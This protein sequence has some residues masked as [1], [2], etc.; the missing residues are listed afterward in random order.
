MKLLTDVYYLA[1]LLG[2]RSILAGAAASLLLVPFSIRLSRN[3]RTKR[4]KRMN[5]HSALSKLV[6]ES[7][8][9]LRHIR[10]SSMEDIWKGRLS[11]IRDRELDQM[12]ST[13]I[14]M[15]LLSLAINLSPVLLVSTALFVYVYQTGHLNSSL[16]F[17]ALNLFDS[18]HIAFQEL[19]SRFAEARISWSSCKLIQRFLNEPDRKRSAISSDGLRLENADLSWHAEGSNPNTKSD[20]TLSNVN[21][22]FPPD[23]L[24][25]VVGGTGSGKSL[26]LAAMLEEASIRS[27]RL[28][29]PLKRTT[30]SKSKFQIIAGSTAL[31]SQ[32][33]WI[34]NRTIYENIIFGSIYDEARYKEVLDACVLNQDLSALPKGDQTIAGLNGAVLSGGQKWR[35][36]LA[37]AFYS[38]AEILFLDDVLSAVDTRVA[39]KISEQLIMGDLA[40]ERTII[41]VT[42][43]SETSLTTAK[44]RVIVENGKVNGKFLSH[45]ISKSRSGPFLVLKPLPES[46]SDVENESGQYETPQRTRAGLV[47]MNTKQILSAYVWASGGILSLAIGVLLTF[48]SRV[49]THSSSWWLSRW[50]TQDQTS[51]DYSVAYS[52]KIYFA[53]S[54]C[55]VAG[56]EVKS[57]VLLN[58]SLGASRSLFQRLVQSVL[59][60]P[61]PWI[62]SM[63][64]GEM[65]QILETDIYTMDN[66]TTQSL[67]NL[68]GSLM[69]L[70][71]ILSSRFGSLRS[72]AKYIYLTTSPV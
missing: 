20:V 49:I 41:L 47:A 72:E 48:L 67:H 19:P 38:S 29:R 62:D 2:M 14:A 56:L 33:P 24:T 45:T 40:K 66:K 37:R 59:Y 61:L 39:K 11:E 57:L 23:V 42:H 13:G 21:I 28:L 12:W 10:L 53:L 3:Y 58:M 54:L 34:E 68:L 16:A 71:I 1:R 27:G 65:V 63:S 18:L 44:Y 32:P 70:V 55:T 17:L 35:V 25:I 26:L 9:G 60:A 15:S 46:I 36:A 64:L 5:A 43:N 8:H 69:N 31:V 4:A 50:T 22:A 6:S 51:A 7:L 30:A 52:M